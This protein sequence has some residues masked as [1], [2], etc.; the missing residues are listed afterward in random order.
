[1]IT[2]EKSFFLLLHF[3]LFKIV[4]LLPLLLALAEYLIASW[5][6]VLLKPSFI[7]LFTCPLTFV[8]SFCLVCSYKWPHRPFVNVYMYVYALYYLERKAINFSVFILFI[9]SS[10]LPPTKQLVIHFYFWH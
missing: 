3:L 5:D 4:L 7:S 9:F 8:V 6:F 2:R 10:L 1:M